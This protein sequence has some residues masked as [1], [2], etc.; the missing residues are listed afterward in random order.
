MSNAFYSYWAFLRQAK[1]QKCKCSFAL[2]KKDSLFRQSLICPR[3]GLVGGQQHG[4]PNRYDSEKCIT[5]CCPNGVCN[6]FK[7]LNVCTCSDMEISKLAFE[8]GDDIYIKV[9]KASDTGIVKRLVAKSVEGPWVAARGANKSQ[10]LPS[11]SGHAQV[12]EATSQLLR[13]RINQSGIYELD[14]I[15]QD[16]FDPTADLVKWYVPAPPL[17]AHCCF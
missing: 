8:K 14:A 9:E 2:F 6:D 7:L 5:N 11:H 4:E 15:F 16:Q 13:V 17:S 12:L 1:P 10:A 3:L